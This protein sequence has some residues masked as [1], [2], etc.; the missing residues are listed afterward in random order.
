VR[1]VLM[2]S[3][4]VR[5]SDATNFAISH[6]EFFLENY[7]CLTQNKREGGSLMDSLQVFQPAGVWK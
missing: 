3:L 2:P 5:F 7:F 6:D 1:N 4:R